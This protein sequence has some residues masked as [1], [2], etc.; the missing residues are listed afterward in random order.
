MWRLAFALIPLAVYGCSS[1][2]HP[3]DTDGTLHPELA[4]DSPA[5]AAWF[6]IGE[7]TAT[8]TAVGLTDI[9]INGEAAILKGSTVSMPVHMRRGINTFAVRGVDDKGH[10]HFLRQSAIAGDFADPADPIEDALVLRLNEGGLDA[11]MDAA[12]TLLEAT[13]INDAIAGLN[14]VYEDSYGLLGWNA[15]EVAADIGSLSFAPAELVATPAIDEVNVQVAL[16]ELTVWVPVTGS[17]LG[18]DFEVDAYLWAESVEVTGTL[19]LDVDGSGHL[20]ADLTSASVSLIGFGYDTSLLPGEIET[21]ILVDSI[22]GALETQILDQVQQILPGLL[23]AQIASL[24]LSFETQV[25]DTDVAIQASFSSAIIDEDG[26]Q[27][28]TQLDVSIP[29]AGQ[30]HYAGFLSATG[31]APSHERHADVGLSLSDDLLNRVLF[32]AWRGDILDLELSSETGDLDPILLTQLGANHAAAVV[33]RADLPPVIVDREGHLQAQLGELNLTLLTPGGDYGTRLDLSLDVL[34]DLE[35][36]LDAGELVLA[37]GDP[38]IGIMVRDSDWN[39]SNE[40]ITNLLADQLPINTILMLLGDF[41]FPLPT[42]GGLS[43]GNATVE[44]DANTIHTRVA[45]HMSQ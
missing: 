29:N 22:R 13:A 2:T 42:V 27:L 34:V 4:L 19:T 40:T 28:G 8:G 36:T 5:A 37:L 32:E 1:A 25:F 26:I 23:E 18:W 33:V 44:R 20:V 43:I 38:S 31:D 3:S 7:T 30:K 21:F 15:V 35:I 12:A 41:R 11:A 14:P 16:P 39:V 9:T 6:S 24:D 17:V 45:L 10:S